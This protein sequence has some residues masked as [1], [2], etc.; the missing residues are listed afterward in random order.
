MYAQALSCLLFG[1]FRNILRDEALP[2]VK[3]TDRDTVLSR[4]AICHAWIWE[5]VP[6]DMSSKVTNVTTGFHAWNFRVYLLTNGA[7]DRVF[8]VNDLETIME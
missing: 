5:L 2:L 6:L 4:L 1:I 7:S 8:S 3:K